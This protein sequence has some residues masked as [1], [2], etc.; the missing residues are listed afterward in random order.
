MNQINL[1]WAYPDIF[2][3]H[4]D[5]GNILALMRVSSLMG[6]TLKIE[7]VE[8]FSDDIDFENTDIIYVPPSETLSALRCAEVL[9]KRRS[10]FEEYINRGGLI[11]VVGTSM[12]VFAVSTLR[13][14][15]SVYEGLGL[16]DVTLKELRSAYTNDEVFITDKFGDHMELVGCQIQMLKADVKKG[17]QLGRKLYGYGN[18]KGEYEGVCLNG[19]IQTNLLGPALVKNP[20]F[21]EGILKTAA[22]RKGIVFE[23]NRHEDY[24]LERKSNE[25]IKSF[26]RLKQKGPDATRLDNEE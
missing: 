9:L 10:H 14:D 22:A 5:R 25:R 3:L 6:I 2:N 20:W 8:N 12:A 18:C 1:L 16:A 19:F 17:Q 21:A 13:R 7:R 24:T 15:G 11:F 26:I 23:R 4:G